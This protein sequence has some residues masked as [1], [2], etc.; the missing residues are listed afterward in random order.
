MKIEVI[1]GGPAGLYFSLLMKAADP[2][3]EISIYEQNRHDDTFGFGVVFSAETLG[4]FRDYDAESYDRIC[5]RFAY[6]DDIDIHYKGSRITSGGHGFC[7]MSRKELLLVLQERCREL[8]IEMEFQREIKSLDEVAGADLVIACNGINSWI[9][10]EYA[11]H[12]KPSFDWRPNK[13]VWLGS[14]RPLP[15]FTFDF[16]ENDVGIWN[17]HAYQYNK[18][19]STWIVET[20]GETFKRAGLED[21][22]EEE[23]VAYCTELYKDL[24]DGHPII[25]NKS[26]VTLA[27]QAQGGIDQV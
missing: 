22:T 18:E 19:M 10:D 1:G 16:R 26:P 17:L 4:H 12:F 13:F 9:R 2:S 11:E 25:T 24:L 23:T 3:H 21:A 7:G 6:W 8:G 5:E 14:T 15:S 20:T 27:Q